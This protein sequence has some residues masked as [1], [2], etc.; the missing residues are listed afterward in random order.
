MVPLPLEESVA[1]EVGDQVVY[2]P[3]GAG[4]I[5]EKTTRE[6]F[7]S[8][9]EY[10]KIVFIR[11]NMEILV[12]LKRDEEVGLRRTIGSEEIGQLTE[13]MARGDLNLPSQWP[14]RHRAEQ[15]ILAKGNAYDLA[16][17]IGVLVRRS[18]EKSLAT[19]EREVLED[20]KSMLS[21]ELAVVQGLDLEGAAE[22]LESLIAEKIG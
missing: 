3:Q 12:P 16:R 14:S 20:A 8:Q 4:V 17:L 2:P 11:G 1:F 10:L 15:E 22:M 21:S 13:T 6:V 9:A 18:L 19:S 5:A 7:G